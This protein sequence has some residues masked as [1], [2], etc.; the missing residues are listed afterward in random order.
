MAATVLA[1]W[2]AQAAFLLRIYKLAHAPLRAILLYP[3]GCLIVSRILASAA[4]DLE[5]GRPATPFLMARTADFYFS[6]NLR[7]FF[8]MLA[9]NG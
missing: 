9:R 5:L 3:L 2:G 6:D 8:D 4:R 7:F 1:G